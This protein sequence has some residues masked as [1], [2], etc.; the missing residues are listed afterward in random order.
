MTES[1]S[2]PAGKSVRWEYIVVAAV[3]VILTPLMLYFALSDSAGDATVSQANEDADITATLEIT[4]MHFSPDTV[5]VAKGEPLILE[6]VNHDDVAHDLK[7]DDRISG[8]IA[9]GETAVFD[10]GTF[11]EDT[12]GWCTIAGHKRQGMTFEVHVI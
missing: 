1:E 9:P 5:E 10:A 6:I 8:N 11:E 7:I 3:L 12:E 4:G 2:A